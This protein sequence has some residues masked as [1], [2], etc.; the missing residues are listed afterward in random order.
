LAADKGFTWTASSQGL[1]KNSAG[2]D[3]DP[4]H[5]WQAPAGVPGDITLFFR[6][7]HLSDL[8]G[9][10]YARWHGRDAA[11]HFIGEVEGIADDMPDALVPVFL[12][13][14]NAWEYYPYNAWYFF[15]DLYTLLEQHAELRTTTLSDAARRHR[16]RRQ[17]LPKLVAGSWVYGTLSTWMGHADKN[18]AW[19][20]LSEAKQ[21]VDRALDGERLSPDEKKEVLRRLATCESSDWFW[22]LGDYN[23]AQSVASFDALFRE[24]LKALYR[25][26]KL[27]S[28][29]GLDQPISHGGGSAEGGGTM[30]RAN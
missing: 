21:C 27:P 16:E 24:N 29:A 13:G 1:L 19:E 20:M 8:I 9:F 6:D 18:A 14:E 15:E 30:R 17:Q 2:P 25:L 26:L 11:R 4:Y 10:E 5:P 28:P 3:A 23:P 7:E 22:W 12:D